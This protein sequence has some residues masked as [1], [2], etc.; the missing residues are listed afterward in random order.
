MINQ[1][2]NKITDHSIFAIIFRGLIDYMLSV[3]H[4]I[5]EVYRD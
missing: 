5:L 3:C 4:V 2:Q 1:P